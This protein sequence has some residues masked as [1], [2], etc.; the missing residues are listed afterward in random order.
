MATQL[1]GVLKYQE[2]T[3]DAGNVVARFHIN[4]ASPGIAQRLEEVSAYYE[5]ATAPD[6]KDAADWKK[7]SDEIDAKICHVLGYDARDEL[8]GTVEAGSILPDGSI[9]AMTVIS[10]IADIIAPEL[11]R[12]AEK[13]DAAIEKHT[14]KYDNGV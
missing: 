3:D 12:R 6:I 14:A 4:P 2:Y 1:G 7:Y 5:N 11:K 13:M 10:D 8:F 9:F